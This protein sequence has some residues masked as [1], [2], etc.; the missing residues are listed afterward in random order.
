MKT[1]QKEIFG[2]D[3]RGGSRLG[4]NTFSRYIAIKNWEKKVSGG[5]RSD[6]HQGQRGGGRSIVTPGSGTCDFIGSSNNFPIKKL[7]LFAGA[8]LPSRAEISSVSPLW[9]LFSLLSC[10]LSSLQCF[11]WA[12]ESPFVV[13]KCFLYFSWTQNYLLSSFA[14]VVGPFHAYRQ[15]SV[16]LYLKYRTGT[17]PK[18]RGRVRVVAANGQV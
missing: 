10:L 3:A 5:G 18:W 11:F 7:A 1:K 16:L 2:N 4:K 17:G 15:N 6:G 9:S 8:P 12:F 14:G 13:S